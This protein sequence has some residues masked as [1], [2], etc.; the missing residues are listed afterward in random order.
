MTTQETKQYDIDLVA[1]IQGCE[2]CPNRCDDEPKVID[3]DICGQPIHS[4]MSYDC[5]NCNKVVCEDCC[6]KLEQY[7]GEYYVCKDH[8]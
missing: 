7:I 6:E 5:E 8:D 4:C 3:C 1:V 2:F